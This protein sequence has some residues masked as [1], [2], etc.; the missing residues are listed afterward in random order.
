V[1]NGAGGHK[2]KKGS[3]INSGTE[4]MTNK[5]PR[6]YRIAARLLLAR[7]R[8]LA[9]WLLTRAMNT[10][11]MHL[12]D[13]MDRWWVKEHPVDPD[14]FGYMTWRD[15][16]RYVL[17]FYIRFHHIK[18]E[19]Q[20]RDLHNHPFWFRSIIIK[21]W[22]LEDRLLPNGKIVTNSYGEGS[23]N[24]CD[25]NTYHEITYVSKGGCLTLVIHGRKLPQSWGFLVDGKHV[26]HMEY[27]RRDPEP[28][29]GTKIDDLQYAQLVALDFEKRYNSKGDR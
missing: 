7:G 20:G 28:Y 3:E 9:V 13:Y 4:I 17:P 25:A 27:H 24:V 23:V 18:R 8:A 29:A 15:R 16:L 11:Y 14:E 5:V 10:P 12:G 22:Y 1:L 2:L 21:G 26:P 6:I 19:D